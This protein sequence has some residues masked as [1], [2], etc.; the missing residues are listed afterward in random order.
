MGEMSSEITK[1]TP[2]QWVEHYQGAY[3]RNLTA[4]SV[5]RIIK[6]DMTNG[7]TIETL[8]GKHRAKIGDYIIRGVAG[9]LYPCKSQ[10]FQK[11]Y[12]KV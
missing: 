7:C 5:N 9:E 11:T 12:E 2:E 6:S 3:L 8:E 1:K 4:E 10:I